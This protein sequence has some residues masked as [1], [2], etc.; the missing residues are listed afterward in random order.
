MA[1]KFR[2]YYETLG[3]SRT[4][5]T[6]EIKKAYRKLARK[7]HPDVNP[8]DKASEEQFKAINEAQAVLTDPEKRKRY[9]QLG[10]DWQNGSDF[11]PPPGWEYNNINPDDLNDLFQ[12]AGGAYD[13]SDFF[14]SFFG[15]RRSSRGGAGFA[16]KGRDIEAEIRLTLSEL[17]RGG[18]RSI[19]IDS[20]ETCHKCAGT[21]INENKPCTA[22]GGRRQT[23]RRKT[24][25]VRIPL[26]VREG[27]VIRLAGQGGPGSGKA[28]AGDLF[29]KVRIQPDPVFSIIGNDDVMMDLPVAPWE[30]VLGAKVTVSTLE[31]S[32]DL[33]VPANSR[34]G[35]KLRLRGQGI[36]RRDGGR[37]DLFVRLKIVVPTHSSP[38]ERELL[39]KL[40]SLSAFNPRQDDGGR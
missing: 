20:T 33:S 16:M 9:D 6:D 2:D 29:L 23:P 24:L 13:F 40:A 27:S 3:V 8:G 25:E 17:H 39:Q 22:C 30:A 32:V 1:V 7:H 19:A 38:E 4:A 34:A 21:G 28:L 11:T 14:T 37:G 15:G 12:G 35:Q 31:G 36:S 18:N 10:A 5:T 26:G